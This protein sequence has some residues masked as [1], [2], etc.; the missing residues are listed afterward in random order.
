MVTF[1]SVNI[2]MLII[3]ENKQQNWKTSDFCMGL[4]LMREFLGKQLDLF[5]ECF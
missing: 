3:R 4:E 2:C 1:L 5:D